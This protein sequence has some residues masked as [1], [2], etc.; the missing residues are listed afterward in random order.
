MPGKRARTVLRGPRRGNA[1]GLPDNTVTDH[2]A[3]TRQA[4]KQ[5]PSH[6][7]GTRPGRAVLVRCDAAGGTH[8][9]LEW[10]TGQRMSYSV[11]F[12]LPFD[13]ATILA[14]IPDQ[15]WTPAYDAD[16][17]VRDGAWVAEL[18]GLLDLSGWPKGMRVICRKERPHPGAQLRLTDADGLRIT[19]FATNTLT[20]QLPDLELRHRRRARAEDRIRVAKDTGLGP[21]PRPAEYAIISGLGAGSRRSPP[22]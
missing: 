1:P 19:A 10:L 13:T 4:L 12:T 18:T 5:L 9:F 15:V 20:G 17:Q 11:G 14:Q 3:V 22:I 8:G 2:I 16:G 6:R 21:I 7:S